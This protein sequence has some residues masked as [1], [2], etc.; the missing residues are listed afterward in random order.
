MYQTT[1]KCVIKHALQL[2][3]AKKL[4]T[5][6]IF[7]FV[8]QNYFTKKLILKRNTF[9][10]LIIIIKQYKCIFFKDNVLEKII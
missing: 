5:F 9:I 8:W 1:I 6:S 3:V 2:K 4:A 10:I 7:S